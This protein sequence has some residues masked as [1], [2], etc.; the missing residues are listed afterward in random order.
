MK[1]PITPEAQ[2]NAHIEHFCA[3]AVPKTVVYFALTAAAK[4]LT[5]QFHI[6]TNVQDPRIL[7]SMLRE[8]SD[9]ILAQVTEAEEKARKKLSQN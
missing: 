5:N 8:V 3:A 4:R 1:Q 2:A 7:A 6:S 9:G